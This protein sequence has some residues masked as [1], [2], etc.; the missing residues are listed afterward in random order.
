MESVKILNE[1]LSR[2]YGYFDGTMPQWRIVWSEDQ[3][4]KR[5]ITHTKEGFELL[6][7]LVQEVP[8]YRQ[9]I[10]NKYILERALPIP[11]LVETDLVNK[12]SYEPVWTF[13]D[14]DGEPLPPRWDVITIVIE[15][16]YRAAAASIGAKYKNPDEDE[17]DP[18]VAI[19]AKKKRLDL[20]QE[21][22]FGNETE[23]GDA[24]AHKQ[25]I[26]VPTS[27]GDAK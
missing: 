17:K 2:D 1:R 9:W 11:A 10:H 13:E 4:E 20:L 22:L 25:G 18:D 24:L 5:R 3:L 14:K 21:E 26:I 8:K 16:I 12:F 7:V 23:T 15:S 19:E 27:Y 6:N